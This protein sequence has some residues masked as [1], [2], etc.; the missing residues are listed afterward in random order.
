MEPLGRLFD[1]LAGCRQGAAEW[2]PLYDEFVARLHRLGTGEAAPKIGEAFPDFAL[3]NSRGLHVRLSELLDAGPLVLSF[4]RGGWCPYC[5]SELAAWAEA[6]P[7]LHALG[8]RFACV[9]GEVGGR[10][11]R[12]RQ[13]IGLDAELFCDVD[14]GVALSLGL[15]FPL[16]AGLRRRYLACGLDLTEAYGSAS[17]FLPIPATYVLDRTGI[18]RFAHADPDFRLRAEPEDVLRVVKDL[19]KQQ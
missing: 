9:T 14:H 8:G 3:P 7:R 19:R 4:N 5:R 18:V 10:A 2:E 17:W 11:E 13:E 12:M 16:E 1:R 15:A 6:M